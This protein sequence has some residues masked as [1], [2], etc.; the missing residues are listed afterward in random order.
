LS[1]DVVHVVARGELDLTAARLLEE[2][3][4]LVTSKVPRDIVL[5]MSE[6]AF[7]DCGCARVIAEAA[8]A[9]PGPGRLVIGDSSPIVRRMFQL[10]GLDAAVPVNEP[11]HGPGQ[12]AGPLPDVAAGHAAPVR[13]AAPPDLMDTVG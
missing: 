6:V 13:P 2:M 1:G 7:L 5:H 11:A 3:L 8:R 4:T 10:T 12:L 9:L